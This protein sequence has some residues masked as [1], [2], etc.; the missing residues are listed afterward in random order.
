MAL[1]LV[2]GGIP[3]FEWKMK[4]FEIPFSE[5]ELIELKKKVEEGELDEKKAFKKRYQ[6]KDNTDLNLELYRKILRKLPSMSGNLILAKSSEGK[7]EIIE[8][9]KSELDLRE[10]F[11]NSKK[12]LNGGEIDR[13]NWLKKLTKENGI[14]S[15]QFLI[16][17][18]S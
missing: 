4:R 9:F 7:L 2:D 15:I 5:N 16:G 18:A 13:F 10:D 17:R 6:M 1:R 8:V 11:K 12:R 3:S 14:G